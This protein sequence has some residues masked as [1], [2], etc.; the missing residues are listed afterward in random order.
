[1]AKKTRNTSGRADKLLRR[2]ARAAKHRPPYEHSH[3]H[4]GLTH[5]GPAPEG[6]DLTG[7]HV[8][9]SGDDFDKL[10]DAVFDGPDDALM[11]TSGC[12]VAETCAGC[13]GTSTG[14]HAAVSTSPAPPC[15]GPATTAGPSCTASVPPGSMRPSPG[16]PPT[17]RRD[18]RP[19]CRGS[20]RVSGPGKFTAPRPT[21]DTD[22]S[23]SVAVASTPDRAGRG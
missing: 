6:L 20:E 8:M 15:A 16:T 23:T 11:D 1:M 4:H 5:V 10:D 7:W 14:L 18:P 19:R 12:P 3:H 22:T 2:A 13:G 9:G 17:R 21:R